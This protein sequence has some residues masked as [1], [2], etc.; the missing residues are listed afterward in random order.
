MEFLPVENHAVVEDFRKL[1]YCVERVRRHVV[2]R[3]GHFALLIEPLEICAELKT[4]WDPTRV[5]LRSKRR[6]KSDT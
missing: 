5:G 4:L 2:N 6:A 3:G 1:H